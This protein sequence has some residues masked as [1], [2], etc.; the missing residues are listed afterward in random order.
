MCKTGGNILGVF[1]SCDPGDGWCEY[2]THLSGSDS[3]HW[4]AENKA[5][6]TLTSVNDC[7]VAFFQG[8]GDGSLP[9]RAQ[10][11][12]YAHGQELTPIEGS[13]WGPAH[14]DRFGGFCHS[15]IDTPSTQGH[16]SAVERSR[17]RILDWVFTSAPFVLA[18]GTTQTES[19][20][21]PGESTE[22]FE[23]GA[24][25]CPADIDDY[26]VIVQGVR[27]HPG[28]LDGDDTPIADDEIAVELTGDCQ[29]RFVWTQNDSDSSHDA[30]F[31]W[32]I[33]AHTATGVLAHQLTD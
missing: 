23:I 13:T 9:A 25:N 27:I 11:A 12:P 22:P 31:H 33:S 1:G 28:V 6:L 20:I 2:A 14:G 24:D 4:L 29:A 7:G 17:D 18:E 3:V 8:E 26:E 32:K 15:A 19:P 21:G 10:S 30:R 16:M 5:I